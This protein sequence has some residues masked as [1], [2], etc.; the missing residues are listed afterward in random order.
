M[1]T[2][3]TY[4]YTLSYKIKVAKYCIIIMAN[5]ESKYFSHS[6]QLQ[7]FAKFGNSVGNI[8]TLHRGERERERERERNGGGK[9]CMLWIESNSS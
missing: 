6:W 2:L 4:V 7:Y 3:A 1:P 9:A 8:C 5:R